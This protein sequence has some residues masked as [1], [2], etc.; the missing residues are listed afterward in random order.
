MFVE[1]RQV[2]V[3]HPTRG[4][5][6]AVVTEE[7]EGLCLVWIVDTITLSQDGIDGEHAWIP[8]HELTAVH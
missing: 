5:T 7:E 1:P 3:Q 4:A 2:I 6:L 8:W